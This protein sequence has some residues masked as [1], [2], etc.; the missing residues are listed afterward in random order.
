MLKARPPSTCARGDGGGPAVKGDLLQASAPG[1]VQVPVT[2][3]LVPLEASVL[4]HWN[5]FPL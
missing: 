4:L 3:L 1:E 2:G 5:A